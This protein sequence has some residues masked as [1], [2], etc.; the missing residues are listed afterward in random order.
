MSTKRYKP[1]LQGPRIE[2]MVFWRRLIVCGGRIFVLFQQRLREKLAESPAQLESR[3]EVS[4]LVRGL[5]LNP[6]AR[7]PHPTYGASRA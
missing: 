6:G 5:E 1:V 4:N 7:F 2:P 3:V